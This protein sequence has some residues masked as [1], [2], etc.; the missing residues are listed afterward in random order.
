MYVAHLLLSQKHTL[1]WN[2]GNKEDTYVKVYEFQQAT[3]KFYVQ[4][5]KTSRLHLI[6]TNE[7]HWI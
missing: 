7:N 2:S 6:L 1:Y 3:Q 5:L 4:S